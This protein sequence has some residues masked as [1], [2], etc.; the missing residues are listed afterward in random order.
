MMQANKGVRAFALSLA[1]A[2]S[3]TGIVDEA[4]AATIYLGNAVNYN[5]GTVQVQITVDANGT[6]TKID[7]P[8]VS[9]SRSNASYTNYALPIL[10]S[11]ALKAQSAAIQGV[12]GASYLSR[13]WTSSLASAIAQIPKA[14]TSSTATPTPTAK[15]TPVLTPTP[16]ATPTPI[17]SN[18]PRPVLSPPARGHKEHDD[19]GEREGSDDGVVLPTPIVKSPTPTV[20]ATPTPTPTVKASPTPTPKPT[21]V[22]PSSPP[23]VLKPGAN[24]IQKTIT[25]VK[26]STKKVIK[27]VNPKCPTGYTLKKP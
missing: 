24:V 20:K 19:A 14:S 10:V 16:V 12:S 4:H 18:G 23:I 8:Q 13:G 2:C 27:A 1:G 3:L 5:F 25:C 7:T 26:G 15:P 17:A 22:K 9:T 21:L 11:E 6:I